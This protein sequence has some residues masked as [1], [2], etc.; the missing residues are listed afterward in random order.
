MR[1]ETTPAIPSSVVDGFD[2]AVERIILHCLE[3]EPAQR[4]A[5]ALA[6]AAALPGGDPLAAALA[7]GE[8]PSPEMVADAGP[9]GAL[10]PAVAVPLLLFILA[11]LLTCAFFLGRTSLLAKAAPDKPPGVLAD[12]ARNI[13]AGLGWEDPPADTAFEFVTYQNFID[14]VEEEDSSPDRWNRLATDRPGAIVFRYRESPRPMI[15]NN[16]SGRVTEDNPPQRVSGDARIRLDGQ[17]RLLF[18]QAIPPH[19]DDT[20]PVEEEPDWQGLLGFAGLDEAS[21]APSDPHWLPEAY[22]DRRAAWTGTYP[23]QA[24]PEIRIEACAYRGRPVFF[25]IY[26]PWDRPWRMEVDEVSGGEWAAQVFFT[27][28]F[29][30]VLA[31]SFLLA[32]RNLQAGRGDRRGAMRLAMFIFITSMLGW[33]FQAGHVADLEGEFSM[34]FETVAGAL[35]MTVFVWLLYV[36]LEPFVRRRWPRSLVSWNRLLAGR[37]RD[38]LVGRHMLIGGAIGVGLGLLFWA[39]NLARHLLGLPPESPDF[40][41]LD[42]LLGTRWVIGE[43]FWTQRTILF[44]PTIMLFLLTLTT[45]LLRNRWIALAFLVAVFSVFPAFGEEYFWLT[46]P[47]LMC[48]WGSVFFTLIRFG[49]VATM[50]L[51]FFALEIISTYPLTLDFS[52]WYAGSAVISLLVAAAVPIFAFYVSLAGRPVFQ[53]L[54]GQE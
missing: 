15:P 24:A 14:F 40:L 36:A 41:D 46:V 6:I 29:L 50:M 8:T 20:L 53:D 13:L 39:D 9:E 31:G 26:H 30:S 28:L 11:G 4:P 18:L 33:I 17:G 42:M 54:L 16:E 22:C 37:I 3:K 1:E 25:S 45:V 47:V 10:R 5:T 32:R 38:P 34:F 2:P 12:T 23:D 48:V 27:S 44:M 7:A 49:L 21:L 52:T 35:F 43:L 19:R 51:G